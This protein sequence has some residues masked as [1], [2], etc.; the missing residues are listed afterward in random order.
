MNFSD[1]ALH[2]SEGCQTVSIRIGKLHAGKVVRLSVRDYG[3]A[4]STD[5]LRAV[6]GKL[7]NA[8]T[9]IHARPQS[10]GLGIYIATQFA[11]AMNGKIGVIRHQDGATFYVD[12]QASSQLSLL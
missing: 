5:V 4:I 1:N 11:G 3:P 12:L 8:N 2:Y 9:S 10:S 7:T 6:R